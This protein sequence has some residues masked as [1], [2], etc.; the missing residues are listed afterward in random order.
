MLPE[1]ERRGVATIAIVNSPLDRARLYFRHRPTPLVLASDA[2]RTSHRAY[3]VA[4]FATLHG[5]TREQRQAMFFG[6][7]A[8]RFDLAGE[9]DHPLPLAEAR[10]ELNT[11]DGYTLTPEEER[12]RDVGAGL[13]L[14]FLIDRDG[15]I[16]W[17]WV[18]ALEGARTLFTFPD[19]ADVLGAAAA[20]STPSSSHP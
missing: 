18:E 11:R 3:G 7:D 10:H 5:L 15:V 19:A 6:P 9:L 14:F 17:R 16:R 8:V 2:E 4:D 13:E 1:L 20:A 12:V